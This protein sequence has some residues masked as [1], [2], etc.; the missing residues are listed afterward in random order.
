VLAALGLDRALAGG[1]LRLSMG[2]STSD[3]DVAAA[4]AGVL[5]VAP[6]LAAHARDGAPA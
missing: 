5:D 6:R 2:W 4:T 1:S 3:A